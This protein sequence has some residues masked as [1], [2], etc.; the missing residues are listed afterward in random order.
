[1]GNI[2]FL[3]LLH[4][5]TEISHRNSFPLF[6]LPPSSLAINFPRRFTIQDDE[7]AYH[8][9]SEYSLG[10]DVTREPLLNVWRKNLD[11]NFNF[12]GD[13]EGGGLG[14]G[15]GG[16][17]VEA[18][19]GGGIRWGSEDED[20]NSRHSAGSTGSGEIRASR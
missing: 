12:N 19:G 10:D 13:G 1:M 14:S 4:T 7:T 8:F 3:S 15:G 9:D 20:E 11:D 6:I 17:G 16:G 5:Y 18:V 2:F